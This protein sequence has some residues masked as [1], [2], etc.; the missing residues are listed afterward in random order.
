MTWNDIQQML[1]IVMNGLGMWLA[2]KGLPEDIVLAVTGGLM[3]A[4]AVAWWWFWNRTRPA[5]V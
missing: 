1:R 3:S 4:A 5:A 2:A